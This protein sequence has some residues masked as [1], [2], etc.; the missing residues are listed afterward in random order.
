MPRIRIESHLHRSD[1]SRDGGSNAPKYDPSDQG[2]SDSSGSLNS[3]PESLEEL[4]SEELNSDWPHQL[5]ADALSL[6]P[7]SNVG[8]AEQLDS[9]L[10]YWDFPSMST[11]D[12]SFAQQHPNALTYNLP[13]FITP[14]FRSLVPRPNDTKEAKRTR[15]LIMKSLKSFPSMM[16]HHNSL[17]AFIHSSLSVGS[18]IEDCM[19]SL[20]NCISLL[21]MINSGVRGSRK[22]FWKNVRMECERLYEQVRRADECLYNME[23][24][25]TSDLSI[26]K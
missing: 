20:N 11:S 8:Y 15:G 21:H 5:D 12:E 18:S 24:V 25:L 19:E 9:L 23:C 2:V 7:D 14:I 17:P 16:V 13:Q 1:D 22:L 4:A 6:V 10:H 3:T 26:P